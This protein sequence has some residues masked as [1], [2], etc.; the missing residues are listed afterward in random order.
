LH[1]DSENSEKVSGCPLCTEEE[2][3]HNVSGSDTDGPAMAEERDEE[4]T[5]TNREYMGH[6]DLPPKC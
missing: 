3:W 5:K 1:Y 6:E 4:T 2:T